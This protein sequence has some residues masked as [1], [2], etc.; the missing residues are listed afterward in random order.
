MSKQ[1]VT[2]SI[3]IP[4]GYEATGEYR[5]AHNEPFILDGCFYEYA[6]SVVYAIILRKKASSRRPMTRMECVAWAASEAS[7]GWV[8]HCGDGEWFAPAFLGYSP[9]NISLLRRARINLDG[10]IDESSITDFRVE[11][12]E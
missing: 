4:D 2:I 10:N 5:N 12:T 9:G 3:E 8:A 6:D 7:K 1:N 11:V